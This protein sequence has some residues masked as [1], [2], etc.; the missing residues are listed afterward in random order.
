[1][2][3][4]HKPKHPK[5]DQKAK[6]MGEDMNNNITAHGAHYLIGRS[7]FQDCVLSGY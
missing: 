1:M 5:F 6:Q 3:S 7:A 4:V 2:S